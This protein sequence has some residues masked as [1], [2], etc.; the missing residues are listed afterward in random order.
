MDFLRTVK[1]TKP[2]LYNKYINVVKR[3][4]LEFALNDFHQHEQSKR[5]KKKE[6]Q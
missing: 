4:G 1:S 3:K 5:E 2:E 6:K